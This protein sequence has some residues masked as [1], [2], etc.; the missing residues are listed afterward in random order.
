MDD[1]AKLPVGGPIPIGNRS[2]GSLSL[3]FREGRPPTR[4][5]PAGQEEAH[6]G[7]VRAPVPA[8]GF[9]LPPP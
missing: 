6:R 8:G 3:F 7:G 5:P 9:P 4:F 2:T 1:R